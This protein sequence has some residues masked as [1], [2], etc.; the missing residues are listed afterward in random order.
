MDKAYTDGRGVPDFD[1][2]WTR[3]SSDTEFDA[4]LCFLVVREEKLV[5]VALCWTSAFL[6]DLAV[7][8][9]VRRIGLG[10]NLLR[11]VFVAFTDRHAPAVD[12]KVEAGN[13]PAVALYERAGMYRVPWDG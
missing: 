10:D 5:A 6:K 13:K 11:Q 2:W 3:F 9:D 7:H 4:S 1:H 8:P 12:L